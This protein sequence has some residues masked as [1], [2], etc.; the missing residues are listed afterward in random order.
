MVFDFYEVVR[1]GAQYMRCQARYRVLNRPR[2]KKG[3][4]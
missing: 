4:K 1:F 2:G 3:R